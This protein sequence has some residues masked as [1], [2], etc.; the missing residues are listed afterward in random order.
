MWL[1]LSWPLP[2]GNDI[3]DLS[4]AGRHRP[5]YFERLSRVSFYKEEINLTQSWDSLTS[6]WLLWSLKEATYK[7]VVQEGWLDGNFIPKEFE[8]IEIERMKDSLAG[9]VNYSGMKVKTYSILNDR[10]V[11]SLALKMDIDQI[12]TAVCEL[13]GTTY[14]IQSDVVKKTILTH[15]ASAIARPGHAL[16]IKKDGQEIPFFD[17]SGE[18]LP[19]DLTLSHHGSFGAYAFCSR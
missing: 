16:S 18:R 19:F 6:L 2:L 3:I 13:P 1:N 11:H 10:Y 9:Y 17:D 12:S 14:Q 8:V 5:A 7:Y 15:F 4:V